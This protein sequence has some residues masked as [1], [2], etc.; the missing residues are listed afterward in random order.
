MK[1]ESTD[2]GD[3]KPPKSKKARLLKPK[4]EPSRRSNRLV[5]GVSLAHAS[6]PDDFSDSEI[7]ASRR[8]VKPNLGSLA[9][10]QLP[11]PDFPEEEIEADLNYDPDYR[12][13]LPTRDKGNSG[14]GILRFSQSPHFRPNLTPQ[15]MMRLGSFG[16]TYFRQ[17][18]STVCRKAMDDDYQEFPEEWCKKS[19]HCLQGPLSSPR[20]E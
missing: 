4:I 11:A 18:Y 7:N 14:F 19:Q 9:I 2:D 3:I 8:R 17:F 16:G 1:H 6:L 5:E 12:A 20:S 13:A 10:R 15:E